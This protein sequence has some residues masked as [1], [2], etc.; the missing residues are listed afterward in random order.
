MEILGIPIGDQDFC[1]F[2]TSKEHCK[3]KVLLS[4]LEEVGIVDPPQIALIL[5]HLCGAF[6]KLVHPARATPSTLT[7]KAFGLIDDDICKSFCLFCWCRYVRY[8]LDQLSLSRGGLGFWS[9]SRH[10]SAAFISSLCSSGSGLHLS[11]HLS[12]AAEIL[13]SL[14]SPA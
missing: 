13:N 14:V 4:Q 10:S 6:C 9:L 11:H 8:R 1:S 12:Q 2:F 3:A 7:T 5:L